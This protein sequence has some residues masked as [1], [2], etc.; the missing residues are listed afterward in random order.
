MKRAVSWLLI[1]AI[2]APAW[3]A[4]LHDQPQAPSIA[5]LDEGLEKYLKSEKDS[6]RWK[7]LQESL[8]QESARLEPELWN[9]YLAHLSQVYRDQPETRG[10]I[11]PLFQEMRMSAAADLKKDSEQ[12]TPLMGAI[13]GVA[14]A[15]YA[16]YGI[17]WT[18]VIVKFER[19]GRKMAD[20]GKALGR[21]IRFNSPKRLSLRAKVALTLLGAAVGSGVAI[22]TAR[23]MT[24][25]LDPQDIM[26]DSIRSLLGELEEEAKHLPP[27]GEAREK[28]VK[29][30]TE[31]LM[32]LQSEGGA[33]AELRER[34]WWVTSLYLD[35]K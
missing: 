6:V 25:R 15:W 3:G 35:A 20:C 30:R 31:E 14:W 21:Q 29:K 23:W 33:P 8:A 5:V 13:D 10:A 28:I 2:A 4:S 26:N 22:V 24:H 7:S 12:Q 32:R 17:A 11:A 27:S 18:R 9:T 34:I 1:L 16:A 19:K